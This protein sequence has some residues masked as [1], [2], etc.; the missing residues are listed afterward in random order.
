MFHTEAW[1][2][3]IHTIRGVCVEKK[4]R[5]LERMVTV[6]R[7]RWHLPRARITV[8]PLSDRWLSDYDA[9]SVKRRADR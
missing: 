8:T 4:G 9:E 5:W 3:T 7:T 2:F 6:Y 1:T